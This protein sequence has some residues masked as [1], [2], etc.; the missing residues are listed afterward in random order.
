M[1]SV[2]VDP[3]VSTSFLRRLRSSGVTVTFSSC[4]GFSPVDVQNVRR[5]RAFPPNRNAGEPRL[6]SCSS[7]L[8]AFGSRRGSARSVA[9]KEIPRLSSLSDRP[10]FVDVASIDAF[11]PLTLPIVDCSNSVRVGLGSEVLSVC[12]DD[13]SSESGSEHPASNTARAQTTATDFFHIVSL[14]RPAPPNPASALPLRFQKFYTGKFVKSVTRI[15]AT[16]IDLTI[17]APIR[18]RSVPRLRAFGQN[19]LSLRTRSGS[20]RVH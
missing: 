5:S 15:S 13:G 8:E 3:V 4:L 10:F 1:P 12:G 20:G 9:S 11:A 2:T 18:G 7:R 19:R 6:I 14:L 16:Q 17:P